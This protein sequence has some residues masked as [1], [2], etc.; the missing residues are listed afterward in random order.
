MRAMD[1][2]IAEGLLQGGER[3]YKQGDLFIPCFRCGMC[4]TGYRVRLSLIEARR[5]AEGLGV[6]WHEFQ[7]RYVDRRWLG[8]DSFYLRQRDGACVFLKQR[9][10]HKTTCLIH[11]FK[12][13][14]C[15]EWAPSLYRRQCQTGLSRHWGLT[16][17]SSGQLQGPEEKLREFRSFLESLMIGGETDAD[18]RVEM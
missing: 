18:L 2:V 10:S 8:A 7:D 9:G 5:I 12:P 6:A 4:C 17:S 16:V 15:R 1:E 13:S 3:R 14:S 11:S